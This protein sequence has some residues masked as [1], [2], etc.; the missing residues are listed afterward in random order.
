[1]VIG[2]VHVLRLLLGWEV[3]VGGVAIPMWVSVATLVGA[4]ILIGG[5]WW[6]NRK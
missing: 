6:E 3:L 2:F 4:L 1:M 5:L